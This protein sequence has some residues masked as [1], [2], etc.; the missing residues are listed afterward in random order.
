VRALPGIDLRI[1]RGE[2]FALL[3]PN[4]AG[5]TTTV[6]VLEGYRSR[7]R[8][9]VTVLGYDPGRQR[10]Q[11]KNEIG[12]VLQS[13]AVDRCLTVAE[14]IAMYSSYYPNPR[15]VAEVVELVGLRPKRYTRVIKFSGAIGGSSDACQ[16]CR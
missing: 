2:I 7:D 5:K 8:G 3:G 11:L 13:I 12:I 15:P 14:A 9:T 1:T 6:E 4:G 16:C 10:R